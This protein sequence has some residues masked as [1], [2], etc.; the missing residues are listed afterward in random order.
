VPTIVKVKPQQ[1]GVEKEL[2]VAIVKVAVGLEGLIDAG[3]KL[4]VTPGGKPLTLSV[5]ASLK[6]FNAVMV[7]V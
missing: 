4:A 3:L 7:V 1:Y 5:S 6:L 2:E